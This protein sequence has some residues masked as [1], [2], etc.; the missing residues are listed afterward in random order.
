MSSSR[1]I[2]DKIGQIVCDHPWKVIVLSLGLIG[3][4]VPGLLQLKFNDDYRM[5]FSKQ[6]Q[7]LIAWDNLLDTYSRS[8]GL[9]LAIE[10]KDGKKIFS[11]E[12]MPSVIEITEKLW[13]V[14]YVSRVDSISNFQNITADDDDVIIKDLVSKAQSDQA[15]YLK[16]KEMIAYNDP[17][18]NDKFLSEDGTV[19]AIYLQMMVP[20]E[21]NAI[22][23]VSDYMHDLQSEFNTLYPEVNVRLGGFVMLNA[24]FDHYAR[25]DMASIF[26]IMLLIM[27]VLISIVF[28]SGLATLSLVI[29]MLLCVIATMGASGLMG[30]QLSPHSSIAPHIMITVAIAT[31]I[32]MVMTFLRHVRNQH[33]KMDAI[34]GSI[35]QN[36]VPVTF[37]S[38]TTSIGF[39]SM[40]LSE[41]PPLRHLGVMCGTGMILTLLI[42]IAFL[43]A[44]MV[45]LPFNVEKLQ[46]NIIRD[47]HWA[48]RLGS[49]VLSYRVVLLI[50]LSAVIVPI[51]SALY[52]LEV[53]DHPIQLFSK[54]TEF[55]QDADFIDEKLAG[56]TTIQFS[57]KSNEPNGITS[58]EFMNKVEKFRLKLLADPLVSHV[59]ILTDT[60][61]RINKSMHY[62]NNDYYAIPDDKNSIAQYLLFYEMN[63]PFGLELNSQINVDKSELRLIAIIKSSPSREIISFL[64]RTH[65]WLDREMPELNTRGVS[66]LVMFALM[67]ERLASN[68]YYT[69]LIAMCSIALILMLALRDWKLGLLSLVPNLLPIFIVFGIW[70]LLGK[71]LDF[72]SSLIFS[73]TLGVVV[74]D[75]VHFMNKFI[76]SV[77]DEGCNTHAAIMSAFKSVAP[78]MVAST[79]ILSLGFLV[80]ITSNFNMN[81]MLGILTSLTFVVAVILDL[82]LL[83]I[84]LSYFYR[85]KSVSA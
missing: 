85:D 29:S 62:D 66:V 63:L 9:M 36:L 48:T 26:P 53:N 82:F 7:D 57:L 1:I 50:L 51:V 42:I 34:A 39:Y 40:L 59:D 27:I 75:T 55:R 5:Y 24:A 10:A 77:R 72:T 83:P 38:L 33:N 6:N 64:D 4:L 70:S 44:L 2:A 28:R 47:N 18:L 23:T 56:T 73:M 78:A 32:H 19:T 52:T 43:P 79:C 30:I 71:T 60:I 58:P 45:V 22:S 67:G 69:A 68:M 3:L 20:K 16:T 8:D 17:S 65:S 76:Q 61:K 31:G 35:R 41:I 13:S 80:F 46:K 54:K 14:P 74:D 21:E 49:F 37:A 84:L 12:I 11:P 81:V 15:D 25:A